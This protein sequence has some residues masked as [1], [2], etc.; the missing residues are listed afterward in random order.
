MEARAIADLVSK[1]IAKG[2]LRGAERALLEARTQAETE[3]DTKALEYV[4][5][6]LIELYGMFDPPLW[7]KAEELSEERERL[8][9]S[10]YSNLQT[11]MIF[12]H[13]VQDYRRAIPKLEEAI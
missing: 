2:D 13:G 8:I 1:L 9:P 5:S 3:K 4:L 7:A 6:E 12:H 11:A 10:A